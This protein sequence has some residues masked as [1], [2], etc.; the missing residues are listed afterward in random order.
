MRKEL[1]GRR[2]H[3]WA[4]V[5]IN[6]VTPTTSQI[7][8]VELSPASVATKFADRRSL[9]APKELNLF[10]PRLA[11]KELSLVL[12]H[13]NSRLFTARV[14]AHNTLLCFAFFIYLYIE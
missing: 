9:K 6:V 10:Q 4:Y 8:D 7:T 3:G 13:L 5:V 2:L 14:L 1:G 11:N 12:S